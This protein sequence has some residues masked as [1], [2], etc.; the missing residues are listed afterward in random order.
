MY[1]HKQFEKF[2][3]DSRK[4]WELIKNI[5]NA[6][7]SKKDFPSFFKVKDCIMTNKEQI[8]EHFNQFFSSIGPTL[9][10]S[11]DPTGKPTFTSYLSKPIPHHFDFVPTNHEAVK[12]ILDKAAPKKSAAQTAYP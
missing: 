7:K 4:T 6:N 1:Y 12:K 5:L 3:K 9:A 10:N 2:K 11:L 8:A